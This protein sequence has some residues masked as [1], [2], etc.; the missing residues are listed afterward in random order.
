MWIARHCQHIGLD[1]ITV[2]VDAG[3][4][5]PVVK[6]HVNKIGLFTCYMQY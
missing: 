1:L 6:Q 5:G 2:R 3:E 4:L